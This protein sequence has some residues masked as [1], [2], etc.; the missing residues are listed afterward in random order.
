MFH[1]SRR[2]NHSAF[3]P[4]D[5]VVASLKDYNLH[6]QRRSLLCVTDEMLF[7][8]Y[9]NS[10]FVITAASSAQLWI[11]WIL[12]P[13]YTPSF[14]NLASGS[15]S[16]LES[17]ELQSTPNNTSLLG[18]RDKEVSVVCYTRPVTDPAAQYAALHHIFF[19]Q[20]QP[21]IPTAKMTGVYTNPHYVRLWCGS[22]ELDLSHFLCLNKMRLYSFLCR[23]HCELAKGYNLS[24]VFVCIYYILAD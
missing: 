16:Q 23:R 4:P 17:V 18:C 19:C 3:P 22:A 20:P 21:H 24:P 14:P 8:K 9:E 12:V 1:Q 6:F 10:F 11:L 2:D 7:G 13:F 15:V 5:F